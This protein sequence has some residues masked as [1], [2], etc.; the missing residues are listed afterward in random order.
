LVLLVLDNSQPADQLDEH[1]VKKIAGRKVLTV[2]NKSDLPARFD[3]RRLPQNLANTA[4]ISAKFG[5]GIEKLCTKI[6]QLC[7]VADFD[8]QQPVCFTSRQEN[9]LKQINSAKSKRQA[10]SI[11]TELLTGQ[12]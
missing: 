7:G 5:T 1:L 9:L 2:L 4:Q 6:Q 8:L 10:A 3:T 11:I 12:M